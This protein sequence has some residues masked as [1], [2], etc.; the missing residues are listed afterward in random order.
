[1]SL[2]ECGVSNLTKHINKL[3][4]CSNIVT[5]DAKNDRF[6]LFSRCHY[7]VKVWQRL[8]INGTCLTNS[9]IGL[10]TAS[11]SSNRKLEGSI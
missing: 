9:F 1:M 5:T 4:P 10:F 7:S 8:H 6:A 3:V 11:L 2:I